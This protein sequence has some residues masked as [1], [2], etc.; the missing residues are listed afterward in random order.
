MK[1][2]LLLLLLVPLTVRAED[3]DFVKLAEKVNPA[4]VNISTKTMPKTSPYSDPMMEF[5]E[6]FYGARGGAVPRRE[7]V[8][9]LGTGFIIDK[10]GLILTNNHVVD[11][12][13]DIQVQINEKDKKTYKAKV[14]GIDQKTD[15]ALIQI[16]AGFDLPVLPFGSSDNSKVGE[17]VAA[18]GIPLGFGHTVTKGILSAKGREVEELGIYPFLQTDASINP[19]NSGGPLVNMKGEVIGVNTFIIQGAPGLGFAIPIDGIKQILGELK[20]KGKITRGYLGIAFAPLDPRAAKYLGIEDGEGVLVGDIY[21]GGPASHA[22]LKPYDVITSLAG[23][24]IKTPTSLTNTVAKQKIGASVPLTV[25]RDHKKL[26]L[27]IRIGAPSEEPLVKQTQKTVAAPKGTAA[28]HDYGF[29]VAMM[30]RELA[31]AWNI[32]FAALPVITDVKQ[33]SPAYQ[34]GLAR[35]DVILDINQRPIRSVS[36]V[37]KALQRDRN[38]IRVQRGNFRVA[39][40][41][42]K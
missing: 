27:K 20:S 7:P 18:F 36:D 15:I 29:A 42:E 25:V 21:E 16:D 24:E 23:V 8:Q 33:G 35:G 19:G 2:L 10:S 41:L 5:M 4:V 22:G 34:A 11:Q 12:A 17:W 38:L 32:P 31:K 28:P 30:T 14:I 6:R 1:S 40:F 3:P 37:M 39:L 9:S 26:N 13:D